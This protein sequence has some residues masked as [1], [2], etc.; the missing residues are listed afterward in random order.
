[1]VSSKGIIRIARE[2]DLEQIV[3]VHTMS[4]KETY[5]GLMPDAILDNLNVEGRRK[6]WQ[7]RLATD[8][9]NYVAE[10]DGNVV[11]FACCGKNRE[12]LKDYDAEVYAIYLRKAYHGLGLG[13]GLWQACVRV[14][15]AQGYG[16]VIVWVLK[17]NP[18]A[19]FYIEGGGQWE[20][21]E[22]FQMGK[23]NLEHEAYG[24]QL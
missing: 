15:K 3:D 13:K 21:E 6:Y 17:D 24:W 12:P 22:T 23:Y 19:Q 2:S 18:F 5:R 14:L 7:E 11:G 16:K 20:A 9:I 10:V 8:T 4:W 1:M